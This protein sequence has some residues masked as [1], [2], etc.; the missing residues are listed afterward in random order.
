MFTKKFDNYVCIG[1][2]IS[3]EVDQYT[4]SACVHFD[5]CTTPYGMNGESPNFD[6]DDPD[7]GGHNAEIVAAWQRDDWF[8][9]EIV[10][11]VIHTESGVTLATESAWG[12]ECNFP[13][14]DNSYLTEAA[15]ELLDDA[16][17]AGKKVHGVLQKNLLTSSA[18]NIT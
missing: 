9:C 18:N 11:T 4:I 16:V 12:I 8:Y 15:N 13:R 3:C 6:V 10:L 17:S 2:V 5:D 7:Y 1:D 14:G